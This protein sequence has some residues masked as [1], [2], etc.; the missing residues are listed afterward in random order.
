L[1]EK[2]LFVYTACIFYRTWW[3][4]TGQYGNL[5]PINWSKNYKMQQNYKS[6]VTRMPSVSL[7]SLYYGI[8]WRVTIAHFVQFPMFWW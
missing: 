5:L 8:H 7:H 2:S 4:L 6:S 1:I 3:T